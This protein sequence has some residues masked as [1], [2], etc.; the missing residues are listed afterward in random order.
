MSDVV[1]DMPQFTLFGSKVMDVRFLGVDFNGNA[2]DDRQ[3]VP[4]NPDDL[5]RIISHE[6]DLPE[7]QTDQDLRA[8]AIIPQ[9]RLKPQLEIGLDGVTTLVLKM[10]GFDLVQQPNAPPLLIQI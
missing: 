2:L 7:S 8:N 1:Q 10:V 9:V 4:F 5:S 3:A 6:T